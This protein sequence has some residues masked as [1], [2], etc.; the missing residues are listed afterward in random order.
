MPMGTESRGGQVSQCHIAKMP[1][2]LYGAGSG[3]Y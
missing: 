2:S 3:I 1:G